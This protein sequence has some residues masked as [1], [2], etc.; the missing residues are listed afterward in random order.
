MKQAKT[1]LSAAKSLDQCIGDMPATGHA[2]CCYLVHPVHL[3]SIF[4]SIQPTSL[5]LFHCTHKAL[6]IRTPMQNR[7][8]LREDKHSYFCMP[9]QCPRDSSTFTSGDT[10]RYRNTFR[11]RSSLH[12]GE[13]KDYHMRS[14]GKLTIVRQKPHSLK[15]RWLQSAIST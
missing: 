3:L 10:A 7:I 1:H 14:I 2:C 11:W 9:E 8:P 13:I 6:A 15:S 5:N 4:L 12:K